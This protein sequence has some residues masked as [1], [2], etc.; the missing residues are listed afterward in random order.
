MDIDAQAAQRLFQA[1]VTNALID[2]CSTPRPISEKVKR[3]SSESD[4]EYAARKRR[5]IES[6][7][8][9]AVKDRDDARKWLLAGGQDFSTIVTLAGYNPTDIRER[10]QKLA[11]RGWPRVRDGIRDEAR[12]A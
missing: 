6:R 12:A 5:V 10:S 4:I 11:Q 9:A 1:V 8:V 2:A 3:R 7:K